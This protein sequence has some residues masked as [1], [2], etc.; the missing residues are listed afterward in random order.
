MITT[1]AV[2]HGDPMALRAL[3]IFLKVYGTVAGDWALATVPKQ[4]LYIVGGIAPK[5]KE[6]IADGRFMRMFLDKGRMGQL[7]EE[8]PVFVVLNADVGLQ[9]AAVH[10]R[11]LAEQ[12]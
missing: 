8:I 12:G 9:G 4:G 6:Q 2:Q 11:T 1:Y 10:A 3:D 7:V 5:L